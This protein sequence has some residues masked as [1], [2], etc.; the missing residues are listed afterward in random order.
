MGCFFEHIHIQYSPRCDIFFSLNTHRLS[1]FSW[2]SSQWRF[3][4]GCLTM[5]LIFLSWVV[6]E[7]WNKD[8]GLLGDDGKRP[9]T[10]PDKCPDTSLKTTWE[11]WHSKEQ[12]FL[13][14]KRLFC[15]WSW[16][17]NILWTTTCV[18]DKIL[19]VMPLVTHAFKGHLCYHRH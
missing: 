16:R 9:L 14:L 19:T 18:S 8:G 6:C 1:Q 2:V 7:W 12:L 4:P 3:L 17:L 11:I 13:L 10:S 5:H 15:I